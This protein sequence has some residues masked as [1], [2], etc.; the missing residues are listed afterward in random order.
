MEEMRRATGSALMY[1]E[2]LHKANWNSLSYLYK[3]RLACIAYQ[4][5][6]E[7]TPSDITKLFSKHRTNYN[8]RDNLKFELIHSKSKLLHNSFI[9]LLGFK[10]RTCGI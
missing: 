2:V 8:L 5:Y 4:A 7:Q 3:K 6:Y 1:F 9:H 10:C